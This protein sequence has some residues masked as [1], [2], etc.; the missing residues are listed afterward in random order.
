MDLGP[1]VGVDRYMRVGGINA[2]RWLD[3]TP[4]P[5]DEKCPGSHRYLKRYLDN[6]T[7]EEKDPETDETRKVRHRQNMAF[8]DK[9]VTIEAMFCE[10]PA[11]AHFPYKDITHAGIGAETGETGVRHKLNKGLARTIANEGRTGRGM[12][13]HAIE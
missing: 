7:V 4:D 5:N 1:H 6:T 12:N 8:Q 13:Y 11:Q 10:T 2:N 9:V 3:R